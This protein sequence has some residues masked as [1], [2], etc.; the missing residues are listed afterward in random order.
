MAGLWTV[1]SEKHRDT[2]GHMHNYIISCALTI[3][4]E[5]CAASK[6]KEKRCWVLSTANSVYIYTILISPS[7]SFNCWSWTRL[8]ARLFANFQV[9]V[10]I[11]SDLRLSSQRFTPLVSLHLRLQH[12]KEL[13]Q[14]APPRRQRGEASE[15][16]HR[17]TKL[18]VNSRCLF[19]C[20]SVRCIHLHTVLKH[21][22]RL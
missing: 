20:S 17:K 3:F 22:C 5:I 9:L 2:V 15:G 1:M 21:I 13:L 12:S 18:D 11:S 6:K 10:S 16:K 19:C 8:F 4:W 7:T 14:N